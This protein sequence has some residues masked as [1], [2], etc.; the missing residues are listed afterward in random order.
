M[1]VELFEI[2]LIIFRT[3]CGKLETWNSLFDHAAKDRHGAK[4]VV[5]GFSLGVLVEEQQNRL[6][7]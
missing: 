1:D 6:L 2:F 5:K 4:F 7:R 3:Y